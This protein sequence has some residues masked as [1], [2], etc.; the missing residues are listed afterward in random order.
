[1]RGIL[2]LA[3]V[4]LTPWTV[5]PSW[6]QDFSIRIPARTK[7]TATYYVL[8][9]I[10]GYGQAELLVDTGSAY[11]SLNAHIVQG[12]EK[13]GQAIYLK[14]IAGVLAD[15]SGVTVRIYRVPALTLGGTCTIRDIEAA[16]LPGD[17][18][19][20]LGLN[21]LKQAAPVGLSFDPPQLLLSNCVPGEA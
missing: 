19:N 20:I 17:T 9:H 8:G 21:A 10:R 3:F 2:I 7:S 4:L 15:G 12:L 16:V 1:M 11:L 6:A 5:V 13:S 14:D 18:R